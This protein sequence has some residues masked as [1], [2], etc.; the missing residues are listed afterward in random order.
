MSCG[1]MMAQE[2]ERHDI[3]AKMNSYSTTTTTTTTTTTATTTSMDSTT[4]ST[5]ELNNDSSSSSSSSKWTL[6]LLRKFRKSNQ[7]ENQNNEPLSTSHH[8]LQDND[9]KTTTTPLL[10]SEYNQDTTIT[11]KQQLLHILQTIQSNLSSSST[12]TTTTTTT[13]DDNNYNYL[14]NIDYIRTASMSVWAAVFVTPA[15][16]Y[17]YKTCDKYERFFPKRG[18]RG[19]VSRVGAALCLSVNLNAAFFVYG[20]LV[21]SALEYKDL[22]LQYNQEEESKQSHTFDPSDSTNT[23]TLNSTTTSTTTTPHYNPMDP[24]NLLPKIKLKIQHEL[25]PTVTNSAKMWIPINAFS[26]GILPSH[27]RP[28]CLSFFSVFWNCYLSLVQYRDIPTITNSAT[29]AV[30]D[31]TELEESLANSCLIQ[32]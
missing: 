29:S 18:M 15:Y 28:F 24:T 9:D 21:A 16:I 27:L 10:L 6:T 17:L 5:T 8:T 19:V 2:L 13:D 26:F 7:E 3:V 1:D 30:D 4:S 32:T 22:K 11:P 20:V 25:I 23:S 14:Q 31:G 12:T